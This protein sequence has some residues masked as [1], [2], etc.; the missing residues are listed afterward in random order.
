MQNDTIETSKEYEDFSDLSE[1]DKNELSHFDNF[2][3]V[4]KAELDFQ[5]KIRPFPSAES[6]N[7]RSFAALTISVRDQIKPLARGLHTR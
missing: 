3:V 1:P 7:L 5:A 2:G 4:K 6:V